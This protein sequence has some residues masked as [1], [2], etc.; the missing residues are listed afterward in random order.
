MLA[1]EMKRVAKKEKLSAI[2]Q[3]R[4]A[5]P[6]PGP[7]ASEEEWKAALDNAHA[8]LEHQRIRYVCYIHLRSRSVDSGI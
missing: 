8:Q 3:T 2:D 5:L 1:A 7:D 4:M 6:T